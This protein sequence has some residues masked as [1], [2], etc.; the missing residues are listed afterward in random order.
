MEFLQLAISAFLILVVAGVAAALY[1]NKLKLV[2]ENVEKDYK[3]FNPAASL[4]LPLISKMA[5]AA[6]VP[7]TSPLEQLGI[8]TQL[9]D[10]LV[11]R[12]LSPADGYKIE[13]DGESLVIRL[14]DFTQPTIKM[15]FD[16]E[17]MEKVMALFA[18]HV[19]ITNY[20]QKKEANNAS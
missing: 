10:R 9:G 15:T 3:R 16:T 17:T 2:A 7:V 12:T 5:D 11:C 20:W 8:V 13:R 19:P 1:P 14:A 6:I 4:G 18:A